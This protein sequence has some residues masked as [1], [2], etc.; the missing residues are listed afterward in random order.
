MNRKVA[1]WRIWWTDAAV[2]NHG[3][4]LQIWTKIVLENF[5]VRGKKK[6]LG[7]SRLSQH[8]VE[9]SRMKY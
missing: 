7:N 5:F 1:L 9:T 2:E 6:V 4:I 8:S 3:H